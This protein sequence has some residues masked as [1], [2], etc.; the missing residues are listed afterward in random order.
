MNFY[1]D[2]HSPTN[3]SFYESDLFPNIAKNW[4][5]RRDATIKIYEGFLILSN[6]INC[7]TL[8]KASDVR[9]YFY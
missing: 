1:K 3:R 9:I 7:L 4:Q 6:S 8:I 2:G 5:I